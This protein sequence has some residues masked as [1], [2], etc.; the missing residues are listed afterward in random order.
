MLFIGD[1]PK[2]SNDFY[3]ELLSSYLQL[4]TY[5]QLKVYKANQKQKEFLQIDVLP[6]FQNEKGEKFH[7]L[8]EI[9]QQLVS[10]VNCESFLIGSTAEEKSETFEFFDICSRNQETPLQICDSLQTI[11][12][13]RMFL[14]GNS[15][16]KV[17]DLY[18]FCFLNVLLVNSPNEFK[19]KYS[20]VYRWFNYVQ[21]LRGVKECLL[22]MK[23]REMDEVNR[24]EVEEQQ[25]KF[26]NPEK[27]Q[28]VSKQKKNKKK[29]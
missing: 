27:E 7:S 20:Q 18:V 4:E 25:K 22:K 3:V 11:L 14:N 21:N 19:V 9:S 5:N 8:H 16:I 26:E 12:Q 29:E 28:N 15:S 17:S 23:V 10:F 6:V 1:N 2:T 13:G 24:W